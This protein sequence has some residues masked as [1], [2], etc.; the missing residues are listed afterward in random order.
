V[1][2]T[3]KVTVTVPL[4]IFLLQLSLVTEITEATEVLMMGAAE[5]HQPPAAPN[6]LAT[7]L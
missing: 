3:L 2:R 7:R 1:P 5:P 4:C 6:D